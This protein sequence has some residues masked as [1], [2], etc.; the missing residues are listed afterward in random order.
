MKQES[1]PSP[2]GLVRVS[3]EDARSF[4]QGQLTQ[5]LRKLTPGVALPAGY[6]SAKGRLLALMTLEADGDA[7]LMRL[8]R[9]VLDASVQRLKMFVLRSKVSFERIDTPAPDAAQ[10]NA[11]RLAGIERGLPVIYAATREEFVPQMVNLDQ[12]GGISFDK[13]CYTGQEI[14]ARLHYLGQLKRR[15]FR[16]SVAGDV[17]AAPGMAVYVQGETQAAGTVVDAARLPQ[18]GSA[19]SVV[20]QLSHAQ[21]PQ[22]RLGTADGPPLSVPQAYFEPVPVSPA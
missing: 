13:G 18:G 12:L 8:H 21:S 3:G 9:E 20:L 4:L 5:D 6:C 14:V 17:L 22:L 11:W 10:D 7:V 2:L 1:A 19:L 15:M 16:S